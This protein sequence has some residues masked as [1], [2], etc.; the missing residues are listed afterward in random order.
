MRTVHLLLKTAIHGRRRSPAGG[1]WPP[2]L[3]MRAA[4]T[5]VRNTSP[6]A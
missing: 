3:H 6:P 2:V 5:L 4:A 1:A